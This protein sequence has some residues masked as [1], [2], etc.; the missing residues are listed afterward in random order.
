MVAVEEHGGRAW[1]VPPVAVDVRVHAGDLQ[2]LH[3][4]D[5][6][7]PESLRHRLRGAA[8]LFGGKARRRHTGDAAEVHQR[9]LP[10]V[11]PRVQVAERLPH[12]AV[13]RRHAHAPIMAPSFAPFPFAWCV[14]EEIRGTA[15]AYSTISTA[16][17]SID[18]GSA[19]PSAFAV[20]P[21]M[22]RS[23]FMG[24]STGNS[25]GWAPFKTLSM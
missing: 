17:N 13:R 3:V 1:A 16:R 8:H 22:T 2:Q 10:V 25:A 21:L 7:I 19:R 11:E 6:G 23:S 12:Q 14:L 24:S 4:L 5:A 15:L 9:L 20:L 18:C